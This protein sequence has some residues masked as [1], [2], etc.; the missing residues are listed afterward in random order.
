MTLNVTSKALVSTTPKE[1]PTAFREVENWANGGT[2]KPMSFAT[3]FTNFSSS[4]Q[5]GQYYLDPLGFVHLRGLLQYTGTL[6]SGST[7]TTITTLP[8]L[9]SPKA[10]NL[11]LVLFRVSASLVTAGILYVQPT[12]VLAIVN[13][14]GSSAVNPYVSLSGVTFQAVS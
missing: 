13:Q 9:Y 6:T 3:N 5:P 8:P 14:T 11:F 12:G 4:F 10:T 1:L 7:M 2:W